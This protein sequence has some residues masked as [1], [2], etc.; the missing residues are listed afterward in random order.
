MRCRYPNRERDTRGRGRKYQDA[1]KSAP[2]SRTDNRLHY[3]TWIK[4]PGR[5]EQLKTNSLNL[6]IVG[7][8]VYDNEPQ[9]RDSASLPHFSH[10]LNHHSFGRALYYEQYRGTRK[11]IT[12][13]IFAASAGGIR[14]RYLFLGLP[15]SGS[16]LVRL[17]HRHERELP[18]SFSPALP[19]SMPRCWRHHASLGTAFSKQ[20][21]GAGINQAR[22]SGMKS[23]DRQQKK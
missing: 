22:V 23:C 5:K 7:E 14:N 8:S 16:G 21:S 11:N 12:L 6:W 10:S 3:Q 19:F 13:T 1:G 17:C 2:D 4:I 20:T 9:N 18:I 15:A